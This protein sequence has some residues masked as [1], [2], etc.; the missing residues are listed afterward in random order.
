[1]SEAAV[2]YA[3]EQGTRFVEE[4]KDLLRIPSVSTAPEHVGDVR[5]A[6]EFVAAGLRAAGM[7]NVRLIE[8]NSA[9]HNG[10]PLVVADWLHAGGKPTVLLYGH[11]DVQ[12]AEP[13]E[14][15]KSPP[16]EPEVRDGNV[17]ARGAVDDKGQMWMHVKA[18]EALMTAEGGLPVNVR[19]IV[20]GEEEVG[21][22][23][24][25]AF[26]REHGEELK[27]DVALVS[28]TE[29]FAP[30]L[31][32]LCVGLRG[33]I[34]TEIEARGARTDLHSGMYGGAAPN[35][36]VALAQVIAKLKDEDGKILIPG[37]Y[38]QVEKPT[39]AELKAWKAL[40]FDVEHYRETEVGS[41]ALT[42]EPGFS[43]LERTWA[44]PTLDVHG[45]PGGFIGTGAKTVIPAKAVAK[46]SMRLVPDMT[47]AESFAKYKAYVESLT[48]KGIVLEVKM[49]HA[50]DPIVVST[51]NRFVKAATEAMREV[52]GKETV[53]VRG[54]GS[55]PIVGDFVRELKTPTV[56]MGFGLPD[57]NLHAP[58]EKFH[59]ANFHRG[60]ES[61]V[62]FLSG[63]GA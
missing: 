15:W 33:M 23:G 43:V 38:D 59:L 47:P 4:L 7:E 39:D 12:P 56:M 27:A 62:R 21:G 54:G 20:E 61:I 35:P 58:N 5:K 53:F 18:L 42:G 49:I 44:R 11:Y 34:Y 40:P 25:A 1:M 50:G 52:F 57:D 37:F 48:P 28:D 9:T 51:D 63:V 30:E 60:I 31:P 22:E 10:H 29:M 32:T 13:L 14:E 24:I 41:V 36:F 17:Y 45:M 19:V 6:A 8:T 3:R 16:F 55:I 46:V 2:G 26:V